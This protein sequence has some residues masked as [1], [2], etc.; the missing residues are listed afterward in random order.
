MSVQLIIDGNHITDVISQV[1]T[2]AAALGVGTEPAAPKQAGAT[3]T[4]TASTTSAP[5]QPAETSTAAPADG[6]KTEAKTLSRKEQDAA[7]A[8]MIAA[9]A[10]DAR[11]DLL[12]KGRQNAVDAAI[13]KAAA[14][15]AETKASTDADLDDM[16]SD[17]ASA[18]PT[19]VTR[20]Q[21]SELMAKIGK[22]KDGN[23]IQPRLL[24]IREILVD[25]IPEGEEIKVKN[26]P[27]AKLAEA[28]EKIGKVTG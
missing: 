12:T 4:Q 23:P 3:N 21:V 22:D 20:D 26:L 1:Q 28:F 19:A 15:P 14:A 2:L 10:K 17:S 5:S 7:E 11:Y 9:G 24:K 6:G 13:A 25:L 27:E 8:E 18:P 16:F